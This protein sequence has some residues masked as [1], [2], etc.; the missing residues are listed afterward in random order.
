MTINILS[1]N[2]VR[3]GYYYNHSMYMILQ[4]INTHLCANAPINYS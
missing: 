1:R 3:E 2:I 4:N